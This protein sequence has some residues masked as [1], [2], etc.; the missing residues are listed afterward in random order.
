MQQFAESFPNLQRVK[1]PLELH[2]QRDSDFER[3]VQ[4][5]EALRAHAIDVVHIVPITLSQSHALL[6][7]VRRSPGEA[8][9]PNP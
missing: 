3:I 6:E 8:D 1:N 5:S 7:Q 2:T 9:N 4:K